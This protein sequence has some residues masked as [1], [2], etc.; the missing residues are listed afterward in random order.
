MQIKNLSR[1]LN[2]SF[3]MVLASCASE[4]LQPMPVL[5]EV[6]HFVG[7]PHPKGV[8]RS[9]LN[10]IFRLPEAPKESELAQCDGTYRDLK[11]KTQVPDE[12][13]RGVRE[14]VLKDPVGVHWCFYWKLHELESSVAVPKLISE[15]Q[16]L[17]IETYAFL[18]PV[19]LSFKTDFSDSRYVRYAI[20]HYRKYSQWYFYRNLDVTPEAKSDLLSQIETPLSLESRAEAIVGESVLE[21]YKILPKVIQSRTPAAVPSEASQEQE[22][23]SASGF[24]PLE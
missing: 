6:P 18:A 11:S 3:V 24:S 15:R 17:L 22:Y 8:T 9:E 5:P 14:W 23:E 21:K 1:M 16:K 4:P 7:L 12:I 2:A 19:S 10:G 20:F 13:R